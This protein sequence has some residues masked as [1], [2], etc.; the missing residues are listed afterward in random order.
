MKKNKTKRL[1]LLKGEKFMYFF[2]LLLV[3]LIPAV[4]IF[5]GALLS[6]TNIKVEELEYKIANQSKI[7]ESLAMQINELASL[8]NIQSIAEAYGLSYINGNIKDIEG[9]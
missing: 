4:N 7:N 1:K 9:E 2:L 3:V 6:E 5:S 8:Q